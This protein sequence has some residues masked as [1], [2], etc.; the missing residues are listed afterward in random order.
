M[1]HYGLNKNSLSVKLG[2]TSN[3]VLGRIVNDPKRTPSFDILKEVVKHFPDIN[4]RWLVTGEG[5]LLGRELATFEKGEI[6][7]YK[8]EVGEPFPDITN[9]RKSTAVMI[10]YGFKEC[11]FAFDIFGDSMAPRFKHGDIVL[12]RDYLNKS[13]L[14]GEAYLLVINGLATI[15]IVKNRNAGDNT[16]ILSSENPRYDPYI[17]DRKDISHL[18]LIKGI[19]RREVF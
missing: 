19:L 1:R 16:Y 7:Y 10:V 15:R 3:S 9:S 17:V 5:D 13:I 8:M 2:L 11:E 4:A 6:R 14:F 18:Y 12:C